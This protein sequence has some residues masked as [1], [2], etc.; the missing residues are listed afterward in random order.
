MLND[1]WDSVGVI[2]SLMIEICV[3][4]VKISSKGFLLIKADLIREKTKL[5]AADYLMDAISLL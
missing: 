1:I 2:R 5:E 4:S 3:L